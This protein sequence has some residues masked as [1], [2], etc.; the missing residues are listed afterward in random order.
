MKATGIIRR[1]DDL[2]RVVIPKDIRRTIGIHEGEPLEIFIE[3]GDTVCFRRYKNNLNDAVEHLKDQIE[4]CCDDLT[5]DALI[6]IEGL[7]G[8]VLDLVNGEE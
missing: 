2:G 3:G 8:E 7:L 1:V 5:V 6:K 4:N